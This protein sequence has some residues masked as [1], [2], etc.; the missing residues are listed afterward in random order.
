MKAVLCVLALI[1]LVAFASAD[2]LGYYTELVNE[3]N[4][5]QNLWK[6]ELNTELL[7]GDYTTIRN[8]LGDLSAGSVSDL[9]PKTSGWTVKVEDLPKNFIVQD[10]WGRQCAGV[11]NTVHDQSACGSCWAVSTAAAAAERL[12]VKTGVDNMFLSSRDLLSCCSSCGF[13]CQGG[14]PS[15]AWSYIANTGLVTGSPWSTNSTLCVRYPFLTCK[16]HTEG[17]PQCS[18]YDFDTPSCQKSCDKESTWPVSYQDDKIKF[19]R[20]YSLSSEADVMR[21]LYENGPMTFSYTVYEDFLQYRSGV[22][23]HTSGKRLGGHA[24][25]LVG[26]GEENGVQYYIVKNNWNSAWGEQGYFRIVRGDSSPSFT[27]GLP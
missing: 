8:L 18:D 20:S 15:A 17:E 24:T 19:S 23:K 13:G 3:V 5:K 1:A 16:H 26:W 2:R 6:A 14:Y 10:K 21:D 27:A 25:V 7:D 22:Y 9:E 4:S 12:C 11:M